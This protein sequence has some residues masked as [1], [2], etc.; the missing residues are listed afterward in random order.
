MS[1]ADALEEERREAAN[2]DSP[3]SGRRS[4]MDHVS[5]VRNML[6]IPSNTS[7]PS[8]SRERRT[9]TF[10]GG[11]TD[12][13]KSIS[14][15]KTRKQSASAEAMAAIFGGAPKDFQVS[16]KARGSSRH[17]SIVGIGGTSRSPSSRLHRSSSPGL[18]LLNNNRNSPMH[19]MTDTSDFNDGD[20]AEERPTK[21]NVK[22]TERSPDLVPEGST[23]DGR[24]GSP[25]SS[26]DVRLEKDKPAGEDA[27][28]E[29]IESS[30]DEEAKSSDEEEDDEDEEE[31][32]STP[33][34]KRGRGRNR[35]GKVSDNSNRDS[36]DSDEDPYAS[37]YGQNKSTSQAKSAL[38]AAEEDRMFSGVLTL[39]ITNVAFQ[40]W[41]NPKPN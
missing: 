3:S 32:E 18:G 28:E 27:D 15:K 14:G 20:S 40:V 8:S 41:P 34:R 37:L 36:D 19:I 7:T 1:L 25:D 22:L 30:D 2:V 33:D 35:V 24:R 10:P 6:D 39:L 4:L 38:A 23:E 29:A 11:N 26:N 16:S 13:T 5:A 31:E 21:A 12:V 9:S 17:N